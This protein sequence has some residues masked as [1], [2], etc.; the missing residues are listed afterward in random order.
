MYKDRQTLLINLFAGSGVDKSLFSAMLSCQLV[1]AGLTVETVRNFT[2]DTDDPDVIGNP[3]YVFGRMSYETGRMMGRRDVVICEYPTLN[4]LFMD[5]RTGV[6]MSV[7]EDFLSYGG[8]VINIYLRT[9]DGQDGDEWGMFE[10]TVE[11]SFGMFGVEPP[12][13]TDIPCGME[14]VTVIAQLIVKILGKLK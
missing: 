11:N 4:A 12:R 1:M 9:G 14:N 6:K 10:S 13:V 3:F 8:N 2:R 7:V 5:G